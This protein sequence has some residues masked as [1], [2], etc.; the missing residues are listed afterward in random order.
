MLER[1][2]DGTLKPYV[3]DF[4]LARAREAAAAEG[5]SPGLVAGTPGFMAP[6]QAQGE[7]AVLDRRTDVYGLGA[8]L[9]AL[10]ADR[11]P[12]LGASSQDVIHRVL[13]EDAPRSSERA[14]GPGHHR[15]QGPRQGA[16][17]ALRLRPR[18][19]RGPGALPGRRAHP[20]PQRQPVLPAAQEGPQALEAGGRGGPGASRVRH[21]ADPERAGPDPRPPAGAPGGRV[22]AGGEDDRE[23]AAH[24][25]PRPRAR[26][27]PGEGGH[28]RAD[29]GHAGPGGAPG[30]RGGRPGPLRG[31]PR[32]P[33]PAGVRRRSPA[34]AAGVER[35]LPRA[36]GGLRAGTSAGHLLSAGAGGR[37]PHRRP[38]PAREE[39]EGGRAGLSR[40][41]PRLPA[42]GPRP[43]RGRRRSTSRPCWPSTRGVIP[44][45]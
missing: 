35:R 8:T 33:G 11:P 6:E 7:S 42:A 14:R 36:G 27:P 4:G 16:H 15:G 32:P 44:T 19:G 10:L 41:R 45:P 20:G 18:P 3:L 12:F 38:R 17:P 1:G 23:P 9:Y 28:T 24:R 39:D 21:R 13:H 22:R 25:A 30:E 2:D 31:R 5:A 26:H 29:G 40:P 34:P 43:G 37:A